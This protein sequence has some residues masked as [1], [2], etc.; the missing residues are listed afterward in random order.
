MA[1]NTKTKI[2][3][4]ERKALAI[5]LEGISISLKKKTVFRTK[6]GIDDGIFKSNPE[7]ALIFNITRQAVDSICN[8]IEDLFT[9]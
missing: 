8:E 6:Y 7:T 1:I 2:T 9:K 5:K 3:K 4:A